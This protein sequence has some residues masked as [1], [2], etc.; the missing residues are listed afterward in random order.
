[1]F[2]VNSKDSFD[3]IP[4]WYEA[5]IRVCGDNIPIVLVGNKV[6]AKEKKVEEFDMT[7]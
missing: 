3:S 4:R 5:L 2:D 1:M 6:D 7:Y